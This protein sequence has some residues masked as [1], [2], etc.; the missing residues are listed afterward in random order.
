M[1]LN[2]ED[3]GFANP[4]WI[5]LGLFLNN[6]TSHPGDSSKST[7]WLPLG[8]KSMSLHCTVASYIS[9]PAKWPFLCATER[10]RS[11][12]FFLLR[13]KMSPAIHQDIKSAA[14][15]AAVLLFPLDRFG[16]MTTNDAEKNIAAGVFLL[17][18]TEP[19]CRVKTRL[20][21]PNP[22]CFTS[23]ISL[24]SSSSYTFWST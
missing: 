20:K 21:K 4:L 10:T 24:T 23:F 2:T 22:S 8:S 7:P 19:G 12:F 14:Y 13:S 3:T 1:L 6:W 16:K 9:G 15:L 11:A 18:E 5:G 17:T